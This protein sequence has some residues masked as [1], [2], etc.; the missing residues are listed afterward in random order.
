LTQKDNIPDIGEYVFRNFITPGMQVKALVSYAV[1]ELGLKSFAILY[2]DE[3]YGK[4]FMNLFWDEVIAHEGKVVGV[5][6]YRPDGTDFADPIKKLVGLYYEVPE[7]LKNIDA[8]ANENKPDKKTTENIVETL[9]SPLDEESESLDMKENEGPE[10]I[11][12]F[13]A[14]FI[15]DAPKKSG[16]IIPQ[17]AFYDVKDTYL[18]GTNL[19]HSD[20]LIDM[21]FKHA[22]GAIMPDGFFAESRSKNVKQF[23]DS[24]NEIYNQKPGFIEAAAYDTALILFQMVS[25]SDIRFRSVLKNELKRLAGFQGVTGLTS[26]DN[27]G[28][29]IKN[30]YLLQIRGQRFVELEQ[31]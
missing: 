8:T 24:Y 21:T 18:F 19:W 3:K 5:E 7:E 22:Q 25:R 9:L 10:A 12:D 4:T 13:D 27:N 16:L 14:V 6:S 15:P 28:D 26:F 20:N 17:L 11:V 29:A 23:V 31:H 1:E 2:P 30:L